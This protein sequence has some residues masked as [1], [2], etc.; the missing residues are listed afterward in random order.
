M[1]L[2]AS[3]CYGI[4]IRVSRSLAGAV[5]NRHSISEYLKI[6]R[7]R[8]GEKNLSKELEFCLLCM[9]GKSRPEAEKH[10]LGVLKDK[11]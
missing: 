7:G 8:I 1:H 5:R 2:A 3:G 4:H 11:V 9:D 6:G 10:I